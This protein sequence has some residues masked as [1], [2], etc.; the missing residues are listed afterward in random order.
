MTGEP[1]VALVTGASAGIGRATALAFARRGDKV[2]AVARRAD[3]LEALI[4]EAKHLPGEIVPYAADVCDPLALNRV[5]EDMVGRWNRFD[6][7]IANAGIGQ[8]GSIADSNWDDLDTVLRTNIDGVLHSIRAAVPALR[9]SGGGQIITISSIVGI[10]IT[11]NATVY[12]ATKAA[13]NAIARGLRVELAKD[14]IWVTNILVGQT[15]TEFAEA[16]RG[17]PGKVFS[18]LPTMSADYVARCIIRETTRH[19]R[20]VT[21][22]WLDRLALAGGMFV[23]WL[24]DR[25]AGRIYRT[26]R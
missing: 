26:R 3:R 4:N 5:V 13:L 21:L 15:K 10:S 6:I 12:A 1:R 22:R 2:G 20:T 19:R 25:I 14:K 23:P 17:V 18:R 8:R 9:G 7:L 11:P 24:V 16:R